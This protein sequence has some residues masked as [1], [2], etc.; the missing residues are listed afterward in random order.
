[1]SKATFAKEIHHRVQRKFPRRKVSVMRK[2]EI[3]A[4]DIAQMNA[5][6]SHNNGYKYILCI[7][8]V[9][10]KFAWS[11][12]LK[13]KN[14]ET[15]LNATKKIVKESGREPEKIWVDK[16]SEFY[17]KHFQKWA[18]DLNIVIYSTYGER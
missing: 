16:G 3:W 5:F 4:M 10:S 17:N 14:A 15:I 13:T 11:V 12:P 9:F 7:I 18:N 1:M 8:D 2:D 6:E